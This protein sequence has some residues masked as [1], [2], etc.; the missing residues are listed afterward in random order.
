MKENKDD[1]KIKKIKVK[2]DTNESIKDTE[3]FIQQD[4]N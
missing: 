4:L 3:E 1:L 2:K